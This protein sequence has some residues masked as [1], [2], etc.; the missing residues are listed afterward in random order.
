MEESRFIYFLLKIWDCFL[1]APHPQ[2]IEIKKKK[3]GYLSK[4]LNDYF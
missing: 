1:K 4:L 3:K 2:R